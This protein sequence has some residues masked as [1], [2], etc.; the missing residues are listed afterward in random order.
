M[1]EMGICGL[2][3]YLDA[4]YGIISAWLIGPYERG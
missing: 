2:W 1:E 3:D 4:V